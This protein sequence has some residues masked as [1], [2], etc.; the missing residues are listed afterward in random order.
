M[1]WTRSHAAVAAVFLAIAG[2]MPSALAAELIAVEHDRCSI[3]L[4]FDATV[5]RSYA[6]S[7]QG[8]AAPLRRIDAA[9]GLPADLDDVRS[10]PTFILRDKG[11]EVG[12]IIGY[13]DPASFYRNVDTLLAAA[14]K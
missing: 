9:Y 12:R 10:V 2:H 6:R 3:C 14:A 7:A 5:A 1:G 11:R 13:S 8:R 4:R